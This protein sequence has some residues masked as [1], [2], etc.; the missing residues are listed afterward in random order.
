MWKS[1]REIGAAQAIRNDSRLIVVIKY[2][3]GGN[4]MIDSYYKANVLPPSGEPATKCACVFITL[5]SAV[6][7]VVFYG[8]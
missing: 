3:P 8:F 4:I 5:M 6:I 1:T 2:N 7:S